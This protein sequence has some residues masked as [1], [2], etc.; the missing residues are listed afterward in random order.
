[1]ANLQ[2]RCKQ[3]SPDLEIGSS[4]RRSRVNGTSVSTSV[5]G[6]DAPNV[7]RQKTRFQNCP[8]TMYVGLPLNARRSGASCRLKQLSGNCSCALLTGAFAPCASVSQPTPGPAH[9]PTWQCKNALQ[10]PISTTL[11]SVQLG[12]CLDIHYSSNELSTSRNSETNFTRSNQITIVFVINIRVIMLR[13]F[14]Q[15]KHSQH[16]QHNINNDYAI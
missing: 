8:P 15:A 7:I 5:R 1:M 4:A 9:G 11:N 6:T 14:S 3:I 16:F 2:I 13:L 12:K 10:G